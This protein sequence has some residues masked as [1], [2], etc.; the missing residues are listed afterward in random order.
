MNQSWNDMKPSKKD[1]F[2]TIDDNN[3][4]LQFT[5][6]ELNRYFLSGH[7]QS[8]MYEEE[9]IDNDDYLSDLD[10]IEV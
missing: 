8:V 10:N 7:L 2:D 3:D 6:E 4:G 9:M 5:T 1:T